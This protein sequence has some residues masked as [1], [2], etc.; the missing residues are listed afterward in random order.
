MLAL[1][2]RMKELWTFGPLG[3]EDPDQRAKDDKLDADVRQAY[4][5]LHSVEKMNLEG[6]ASRYGGTWEAGGVDDA[7]VSHGAAANGAVS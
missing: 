3:K 2:R 5:L 7:S 4:A 6:L 1:S